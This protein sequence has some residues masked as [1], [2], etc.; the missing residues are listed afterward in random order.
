MRIIYITI[1]WCIGIVSAYH[2]REI[3]DVRSIY[4]VLVILTLWLGI[5]L[6]GRVGNAR[7]VSII[8]I[9]FFLGG[10]WLAQHDPQNT[11]TRLMQYQG[12][13]VKLI[14]VVSDEPVQHDQFLQ[15]QLDVEA[16]WVLGEIHP[17][18]ERVLVTLPP[19][20]KV[21]YGDRILVRGDL[22]P[23]PQLDEFSYRD[24]LARQG[25]FSTVNTPYVRVLESEQGHPV[26]HQLIAIKQNAHQFIL[27]ALPEP[28]AG[29]LVGILLGDESGLAPS[30]ESA[31][32]ETGTSHI[33]AISG[34]NMTIISAVV[35][36]VLLAI[37]RRRTPAVLLSMLVIGLYTVLVGAN[38]AV[39]R[40]ALMSGV[41]IFGKVVKRKG[42][43]PATLALAVLLMSILEPFVLW[44]IGFQLSFAAVLGMMILVPPMERP[45]RKLWYRLAGE[46]WGAYIS[47][48]LGEPVVVTLA[49]QI[50]TLPIILTY[51]GHFS[52]ISI[53]ANFLI[54]P[55]QSLILIL[56]G[57]GVLL[58]FL[59]PIL[60]AP[61]FLADWVLLTYTTEIVRGMADMTNPIAFN[62][63][64]VVMIA[65]IGLTLA[66]IILDAT[67]SRWLAELKTEGQILFLR[68]SIRSIPLFI[69]IVVLGLL[70]QNIINQPDDKLHVVYM[71][72]GH[73]QS[74][75]IRTPEGAVMM[76]DGGSF[77]SR[78]LTELGDHLPPNKREIDV[79]FI[80]SNSASD[81]EAIATVADRYTI[82]TVIMPAGLQGEIYGV[83]KDKLDA[84]GV[85]IIHPQLGYRVETEDGV[86]IEI[87]VP[88][89]DIDDLVI[90]LQYKE[91]V[92]LFPSS[93]GSVE[94]QVLLKNPHLIQANVLLATDHATTRTNSQ[95]WVDI[96][97]PQIVIVQTDPTSR[98]DV[99]AEQVISHFSG[100]KLYRTD[101]HGRIEVITDGKALQ[102][103]TEQ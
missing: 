73:S 97:N 39:L 15:V 78:L 7:L 51:F 81:I 96:V 99:T 93:I 24:Y 6:H 22:Y 92:F 69:G 90:R 46:K 4:T 45:F 9:F 83:V 20:K 13:Y 8:I 63:S 88:Q 67:R 94:E 49:A 40:A 26:R 98:F 30:V 62:L 43:L 101:Q 70:G 50:A 54:I 68:Q 11:N 71:D 32:E 77:P 19:T 33:I 10:L 79:W 66:Y 29:L 80:T 37:F 52:L 72:M 65:M 86:H 75:L 34:F 14:G 21:E 38:A 48:F 100:Q 84:E 12:N 57:A 1:T 18:H 103:V 23:P 31:F 85:T 2:L 56:G 28:Q 44:N 61:F 76:I 27:D 82:Q 59:T 74:V 5:F 41:F 17:A 35:I 102:I 87:L 91:A 89:A 36:G 60:G 53:V 16:V 95:L 42:Y 3:V 58:S 25:I 55:A 47:N 64:P